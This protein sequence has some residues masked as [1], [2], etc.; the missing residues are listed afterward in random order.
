MKIH[1]LLAEEQLDELNLKGL[2]TGIGKAIGAVPGAAVQGAKNV[3]SGV[4]QGWNSGQQ[5]LKPEQTPVQ[6]AKKPGFWQGYN[7]TV[8]GTTSTVTTSTDQ[9]SP[10][11]QT[12]T[13]QGQP[14]TNTPPVQQTPTTTTPTTQQAPANTPT[15]QPP[16][17]VKK[18][19]VGVPAG[20]Q[21]VDQAVATVKSVRSD[22]RPQ[23]IQ[24]AKQKVD[25]LAQ[26]NTKTTTPQT[27]D[28]QTQP[29][30]ANQMQQSANKVA[31]TVNVKNNLKAKE[32]AP[33]E[34]FRSKFLGIDL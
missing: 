1:E 6:G 21:A 9:Q 13:Q 10:V 16:A 27:T 7:D 2:G 20:K 31:P 3:W 29:N 34:G 28:T 4:K 19:K 18:V 17:T 24:Y 8:N 14:T 32:P 23:V 5:A 33:V 25:D 22:R 12:P 11:Q 30:Y 15:T 26:Q